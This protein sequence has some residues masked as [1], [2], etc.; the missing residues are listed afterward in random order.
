MEHTYTGCWLG[1]VVTLHSLMKAASHYSPAAMLVFYLLL[2][3]QEN[4]SHIHGACSVMIGKLR[5]PI[6][7]KVIHSFASRQSVGSKA[8]KVLPLP[9]PP[10]YKKLLTL[11]KATPLFILKSWSR[12]MP[13][14]RGKWA[15]AEELQFVS[16]ACACLRCLWPPASAFVFQ[17][18][19]W[20]KLTVVWLSVPSVLPRPLPVFPLTRVMWTNLELT[21]FP[22]M[23]LNLLLLPPH[24][25]DVGFFFWYS[26]LNP[27]PCG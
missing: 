16:N 27:G 7:S 3:T 25:L 12:K 10:V 18:R 24:L 17:S 23:N 11:V 14:G 19:V 26:E 13:F 22:R 2:R 9:N 8:T 15:L 20:I 1:L 6:T 5:Q 4:K 21:L